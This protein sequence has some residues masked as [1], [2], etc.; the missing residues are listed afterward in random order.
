MF[1]SSK[2]RKNRGLVFFLQEKGKI[3][4]SPFCLLESSVSGS[5]SAI[6][7]FDVASVFC[8]VGMT[9]STRKHSTSEADPIAI[10]NQ[11]EIPDVHDARGGPMSSV[12]MNAV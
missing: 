4:C 9:T 7:E 10:G 5:A 2:R 1:W 3:P 12:E 11:S 8:V 6:D